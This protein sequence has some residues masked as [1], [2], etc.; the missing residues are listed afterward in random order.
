M[1]SLVRSSYKPMYLQI[2]DMIREEIDSGRL[3]LGDRI[4]SE[5]YIME[6][7][8]V[9]RNTALK[10]IEELEHAGLV[11]RIQGKGTFVADRKVRYG[12]QRLTSFSEEMRLKGMTP[13]SHVIAMVLESS[14]PVL[15]QKLQITPTDLVYKLDRLRL[16]DRQ[17]MAY[18]TSYVPQR[19]CPG[20]DRRDFS[21]ESLFAVIQNDYGLILSW[22][23]Q[24]IKP[25]IASKEEAALLQI[26]TRS[27][28]LLAVGVAYL[29]DGTPIETNRILYRSDLYEFTVRSSRNYE[30]VP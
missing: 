7:F 8:T 6:Q 2:S 1:A 11:A 21:I 17:P 28:L 30:A 24:T 23:E 27:P 13:S 9:S 4:W 3:A 12:L 29:E 22:Q 10:A 18:H 14:T 5:R 16:A 20:L 26:K 19:L 15:A 25:V